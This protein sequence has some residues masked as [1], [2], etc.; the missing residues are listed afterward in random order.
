MA[1]R[2]DDGVLVAKAKDE[3]VIVEVMPVKAG[4]AD[5]VELDDEAAI[6]LIVAVQSAVT[7]LGLA[8]EVSTMIP[9]ALTV[10]SLRTMVLEPMLN[11]DVDELTALLAFGHS[12]PVAV[13]VRN[14][15]MMLLSFEL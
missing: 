5:S 7:T 10:V 1:M 6:G 14:A 9:V 11:D 15:A 4:V 12:L 8:L 3:P 13:P 2:T